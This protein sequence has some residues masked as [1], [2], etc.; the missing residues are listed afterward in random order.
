MFVR[1]NGIKTYIKSIVVMSLYLVCLF[2]MHT[3]SECD[4]V[5]HVGTNWCVSQI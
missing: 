2:L 1:Q 5:C 4:K 3:Q